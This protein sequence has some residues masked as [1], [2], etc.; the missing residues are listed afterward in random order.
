VADVA[1]AIK[2]AAKRIA[3]RAEA[4]MEGVTA[5][6]HIRTSAFRLR[7]QTWI[8]TMSKARTSQF[9]LLTR[10]GSTAMVMESAARLDVFLTEVQLRRR[11]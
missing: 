8:V 10:M 4:V 5:P 3:T 2:A 11:L 9:V 6:R 1:G 7:P